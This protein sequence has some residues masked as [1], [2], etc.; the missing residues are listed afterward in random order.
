MKASQGGPLA[1]LVAAILPVIAA[2]PLRAQDSLKID[3]LRPPTAPAFV[4]LGAAPTQIERPTS[5]RSLAVS[6]AS[7]VASRGDNVLPKDYAL[8]V[9]PYWL[10]SH[11]TLTFDGY[12]RPSLLQSLL[13]SLAVSLATAPLPDTL[14]GGTAVAI[15]VRTLLVPGGPHPDLGAKEDELRAIQTTMNRI[16]DT[17]EDVRDS[18]ARALGNGL[19]DNEVDSLVDIEVDSLKRAGAWPY[20]AVLDR[21]ADSARDVA[22]AM[23]QL[24]KERVGWQVE[25]A[26]ALVLDYPGMITDSGRVGRVGAWVTIAHRAPVTGLDL[27]AVFRYR[28]DRR[29]APVRNLFDYG[30]RVVWEGKGLNVSGEF[31]EHVGTKL[32]GVAPGYRLALNLEY[33]VGPW[34]SLTATVGN[35]DAVDGSAGQR[36]VSSIGFNLGFGSLPLLLGTSGTR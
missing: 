26:G 29:T 33:R 18:L 7:A 31:L 3:D 23:Q 35:D 6:L 21:Y 32:A 8:E 1:F 20:D 15:G 27:M 13:Q 12:Y 10:V 22:L 28:H 4:L 14:L 34:G 16:A 9:A 36:L 25:L 5:P 30:G 19:A 11:P 2:A 24:D 17:A